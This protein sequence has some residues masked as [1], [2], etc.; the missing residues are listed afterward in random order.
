MSRASPRVE[1][2]EISVRN[3]QRKVR[4]DIPALQGFAERALMGCLHYRRGSDTQL[5]RLSEISIL[6]ISDRR[7]C[8]LHRRFLNRS[9]STDVITFDHGEIFISVET[10]RKH[11]RRFSSSVLHEVQLYIIHGLLHLHGFDDRGKAGAREMEEV[12]KKILERIANA[13]R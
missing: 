4:V 7:M 10:A 12:Q 6:L 8:D 1:K 2:P 13:Q 5:R 3:L 9:G 11:A